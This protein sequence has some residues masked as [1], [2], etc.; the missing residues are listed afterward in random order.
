MRTTLNLDDDVLEKAKS[1]A[2]GRSVPLGAAVSE[3]IR[4]GLSA[5]RPTRSVHGLRVVELPPNS[6]R[7][8]SKGIRA[9]EA[10]ES[11]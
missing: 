3:L 4:R 7:V 11:E 10:E 9:L 5:K 6:P 1:Y 2:E 8:T